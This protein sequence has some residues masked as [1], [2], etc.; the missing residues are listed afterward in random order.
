MNSV[1]TSGTATLTAGFYK[2]QQ[3]INTDWLWTSH[4]LEVRG[5]G[6]DVLIRDGD[7]IDLSKPGIEHFITLIRDTTEGLLAL[8]DVPPL[9]VAG[10][11]DFRVDPGGGGVACDH[12]TP[13]W[14]S[15]TENNP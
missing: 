11:P 12:P 10:N 2:S 13:R 8:P 7:L 9:I 14:S 1:A 6:Q 3:D 5:G 15:P 4:L